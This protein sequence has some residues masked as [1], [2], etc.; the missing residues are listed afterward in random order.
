MWANGLK[1]MFLI[2]GTLIGAGYAS[3]REL[4]Q[5]FGAESNVAILLF[6]GLFTVSCFVILNLAYKQKST[7]YVPLLTTLVGPKLARF[8]DWI[9]LSYLFS[10]TTIMLAGAGA[11][12]EVYN[13]PFWLGMVGTAAF[14]VLLFLRDTQGMTTINAFLI[15]ILILSLVSILL[16]F[17]SSLGF[18]FSFDVSH[19][20]N[21]PSAITFTALNI[22]PIVAVVSA[23]GNQISHRGEIWIATI[24][25]GLLMGSISY[26]YNES[27]LQIAN[28]IMFYEIPLF[29][30]LK[31]YPSV[32]V[33]AMSVLLWLAIYTTAGAGI[34]GLISRLRGVL[35]GE[36]WL[37]A[38]LLL[39]IMAPL[40]TFG[41]SSMIAVLYPLYG[42][43]NLYLLVAI[44]LYPFFRHPMSKKTL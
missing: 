13:I 41:F 17:Q 4:W 1:W 12:L 38:M 6:T 28:E 29:V 10:T 37:V 2:V 18:S 32:M 11:T 3:G 26:L 27:L 8:Y 34:F 21:W 30:I 24:G 22:L 7:Q 43:V 23:I 31:Q 42:A 5:F 16:V 36:T 40:T 39:A 9:I 44:I 19:Q 33:V 14:V 25:S 35:K 20:S 15:P